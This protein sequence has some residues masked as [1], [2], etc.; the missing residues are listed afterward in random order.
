[1]EVGLMVRRSERPGDG[2]GAERQ[3]VKLLPLES[4][5]KVI[6]WKDY[7]RIGFVKREK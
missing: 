5:R 7:S 2:K 1:M 3:V 6:L 4:T